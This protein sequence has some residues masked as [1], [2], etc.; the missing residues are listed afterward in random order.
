MQGILRKVVFVLLTGLMAGPGYTQAWNEGPA[1]EEWRTLLPYN[2]IE[3]LDTDGEMIFCATAS[4]FFTYERSSGV[5]ETYSKATGMHGN[6]LAD[7]AYDE[8]TGTVVLAYKNS[9][10]DFFKNYRFQN[11]PDLKNSGISGD[12][13]I[14]HIGAEKGNA[15]VSTGLGL[16]ILNLEKREVKETVMFYDSALTVPVYATVS[17]GQ[18]IY[19]ATGSGIFR[20][21]VGNPSIQNYAT[22]EVLTSLPARA[23]TISENRVYA[24]SGDSLIVLDDHGGFHAIF[25]A[26][27]PIDRLDPGQGGVWLSCIPRNNDPLQAGRGLLI[28]AAGA[29]IDSVSTFRPSGVLQFPSGEIWYGD[30]SGYDKPQFYGLRKKVSDTETSAII[31]AGPV[32][33]SAFD[34][35]AYNGELWI[36]HGGYNQVWNEL[37]NFSNYSVFRPGK[38][39]QHFSWVSDNWMVKDFVRIL[40]DPITGNV[41]A[42]SYSGG[43][44]VDRPGGERDIYNV[45]YLPEYFGNPGYCR[46][47]GLSLDP[48]GNLWIANNGASS[49]LSVMTPEGDFHTMR[50]V[51]DNTGHPPHSASD[52]IVDDYGQKWFVTNNAGNGAVVYDDRGTLANT[53]DDRA[54]VFRMGEG[55]G[56]LPDNVAL[57]IAKDRDGAIWIGTANGIGIVNCPGSAFGNDCEAEL[58]TV[59]FD[60]FADYLFV[61]QTVNTIAVDGANR[62]WVGTTNGAWLVSADAQEEIYRFTAENSPL[63]SNTIRRINIDP[64]TGDVYFSTDEGIACFRST[65]TKGEAAHADPLLIYPNPVPTGYEGMVA[66]RGVADNSD[67]RITDVSGQLVYRTRAAGGQAVWNGRDYTGRRV[68]SGVYL[69]FVVSRD[70]ATKTTGKLIFH[71]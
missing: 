33:P 15:Y 32:V 10:I 59:K 1:V 71:E 66:I 30:K 69:I 29:L 22:W 18:Q 7:L 3:A 27:V 21:D 68:Q 57:S 40:K 9:D 34:I 5:L 12:K 55:S 26:G 49:E 31:P 35:S 63:P 36:A 52:V 58:R 14:Y 70:G 50:P 64:V 17:E 47:A 56:N 20:T 39:W 65:A 62:K 19:A 6:G 43:L 61:N 53:S 28:D 67:V 8:Q 16:V 42:A 54:R 51:S 11:L 45:G 44:V 25:N 23:V 24:A 46:T 60:E 41:Y 4:G 48:E 13:T 38:G 37:S 2:Q